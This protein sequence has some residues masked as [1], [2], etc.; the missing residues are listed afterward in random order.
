MEY[1]QNILAVTYADLEAVQPYKTTLDMVYNQRCVLLRRGYGRDTYALIQWSS[2]PPKVQSKFIRLVGDPVTLMQQREAA[3]HIEMRHDPEAVKWFNEFTYM[4]N[5]KKR[6]LTPALRDKYIMN[7]TALKALLDEHQKRVI[8]TKASNNTRHDLWDILRQSSERMR[9]DYPHT[10]P[11]AKDPLRKLVTTYKEEGMSCV[12]S[13]KLGNRNTVKIT[14]QSLEYLVSLR[15]CKVP[16]YSVEDIFNKYNE[17]ALAEGWKQLNSI[18]NLYDWFNQEDIKPRWY[19]AVHGEQKAHQKFDRKHSTELPTLANA[20]WYGD[21]TKLNLYY[22]DDEGKV[23]TTMVYEVMDVASEVMLGYHISDS[24]DYDAQYRAYR[25]AVER[26][27]VKPMEVVY[28]NQGGHKKLESQNFFSKLA[29]RHRPTAPYNGSSKTIENA[30]YRFQR[31][32]LKKYWF[33][34]GQNITA[35]MDSSRPDIEFIEANRHNLPTLPELKALYATL[36]EEWNNLAHPKVDGSRLEVYNSH[37][38]PKC[39]VVT[40][41]DIIEMFW[42][43]T[44]RPATFTANGLRVT[45]HGREH[46]YEV[47]ESA[48]VPDYRWATEH[49]DAKFLVQ[50]DPMDMHS[51]RLLDPE[52]NRPVAVAETKMVIHRASTEQTEEERRFIRESREALQRLRAERIAEARELEIKHGVAPEQYGLMSPTPKNLPKELQEQLDR[53]LARARGKKTMQEGL[54]TYTKNI[55]LTDWMAAQEDSQDD[56]IEARIRS[57]Y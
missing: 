6:H 38:H 48:G 12:V 46:L 25:M 30:F 49:I 56:N 31:D 37:P 43:T 14:G 1:Y 16:F 52:D 47:Y 5:G 42:L 13:G 40:E 41:Y 4:L 35:K 51:V 19:D 3:R 22:R 57:K 32:V 23:R 20:I 45:I 36:R 50:Y 11:T 8:R 21:G 53:R 26:A 10:L 15:R 2:L 24:E 34:T 29:L 55:S 27:G 17:K 9:E 54:G 39:P 33:F 44:T 28:D 18:G 7:A